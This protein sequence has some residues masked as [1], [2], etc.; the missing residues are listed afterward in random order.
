[1]IDI[2]LNLLIFFSMHHSVFFRFNRKQFCF[3][4]PVIAHC[5][6]DLICKIHHKGQPLNSFIQTKR[7][8]IYHPILG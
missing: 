6:G 2:C 4:Q 1:M 3:Q 5:A 7:Q 8:E